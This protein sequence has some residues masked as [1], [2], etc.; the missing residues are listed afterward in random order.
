M[1]EGDKL[2]ARTSGGELAYLDA[3]DPEDPA[4][5]FL[6]GFPTSSFLWR[7]VA[8]L[9]SP[10]MR[11]IAPDLLGC[12]DSDKPAD[13]DLGIVAQAG[14]VRELLE[15]RGIG[16]LAVVGHGLGGGVAQL[17]ALGGGVRAMV[18]LDSVAFDGW[19]AEVTR[20][21]QRQA[22]ESDAALAET[23]LRTSFDLGMGH[24][25]RLTEDALA[26]YLRPYTGEEGSAA[27]FRFLRSMDGRG[28]AG[29]EAELERL[30]MPVLILWGE[31]DPFLPV[32]LAERLSD[33]LP[34]STLALLPGC[35]HFLPEDAPETI[36]PLMF[37][38]LR[39]W[40]LQVPHVHDVS[41]PVV[42]ELGRRLQEVD[43]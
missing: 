35:S 36:S 20:E 37:E 9:F 22:P 7:S 16:S 4:V 1:S 17:L 33:A 5:L 21:A 40:Y 19:P 6:H 10:W 8:P 43:E 11:V 23:L 31:D 2:R 42:L 26:E 13:A 27:C 29:R 32:G 28:L 34:A 30:E 25:A 12:G 39:S 38:Y 14:Y 15:G 3:G 41:A 18:L 24:R